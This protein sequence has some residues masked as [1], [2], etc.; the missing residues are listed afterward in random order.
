MGYLPKWVARE[1]NNHGL[2]ESDG[3]SIECPENIWV[4]LQT[5]GR[6]DATSV[7]DSILLSVESVFVLSSVAIEKVAAFAV[8]Y[9]SL[10][11]ASDI[12]DCKA[13]EIKQII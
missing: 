13:T 11:G 8:S 7:S 4:S 10:G 1:S 2:N 12:V 9:D 5:E 3:C 6:F